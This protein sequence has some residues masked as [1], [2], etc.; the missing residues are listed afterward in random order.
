MSQQGA[1]VAK[2][3]NGNLRAL[4]SVARRAG[5]CCPSHLCELLHD[6]IRSVFEYICPSQGSFKIYPL[7][8][9]PRVPLP[10]RQFHQL[11]ARGPQECLVRVYIIRAFGLQPK[12][13]N[14]KVRCC[15]AAGN[16]QLRAHHHDG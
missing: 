3:A 16:P 8:D 10:P 2:K 14:G 7:P 15:G 5:R 9:D 4:Q 13:A 11:P 1:L 6:P 12:D